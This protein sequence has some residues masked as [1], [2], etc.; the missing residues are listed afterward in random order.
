MDRIGADVRVF[1][2]MG[3]PVKDDASEADPKVK[4]LRALSEWSVWAICGS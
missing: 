2:P 3:L 4:E 1:N